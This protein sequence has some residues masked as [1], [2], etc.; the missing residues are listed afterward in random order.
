M[1]KYPVVFPFDQVT[2]VGEDDSQFFTELYGRRL[3]ALSQRY[4]LPADKEEIRV[5]GTRPSSL[6]NNGETLAA[7]GAP[8]PHAAVPVW[9]QELRWSRARRAE[10]QG[11][12]P[13]PCSRPGYWWRLLVCLIICQCIPTDTIVTGLLIWQTSSQR[14]R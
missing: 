3:S 5:S 7:L 12:P 6:D 9:W 11:G 8:P 14:W 10:P 4:M 2:Y 1:P 13:L